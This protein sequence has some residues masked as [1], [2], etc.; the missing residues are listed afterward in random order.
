MY[1]E[2]CPLNLIFITVLYSGF[3]FFCLMN[4]SQLFSF[5]GI[6]LMFTYVNIFL[7]KLVLPDLLSC[8]SKLPST[9]WHETVD[10][11]HSLFP[12]QLSPRDQQ[13]FSRR[14]SVAVE[15]L[16][17]A[18]LK[19][20]YSRT[21][22]TVSP[23]FSNVYFHPSHQDIHNYSLHGDAVGRVTDWTYKYSNY[24]LWKRDHQCW[25]FVASRKCMLTF[26]S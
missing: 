20:W 6:K 15:S 14:Q 23:P 13:G 18:G 17:T 26:K 11:F 12:W 4:D 9:F 16:F 1:F 22:F 8:F 5:V 21:G 2:I 19:L 24:L 25:L 3:L 10:L 7:C